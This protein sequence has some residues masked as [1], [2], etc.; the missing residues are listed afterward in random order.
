MERIREALRLDGGW[1]RW[2]MLASTL[3]LL[4]CAAT[5]VI[6]LALP[7]AA[8]N[9]GLTHG[10]LGFAVVLFALLAFVPG[11]RMHGKR[12]VLAL[13]GA[14]IGLIWTAV[15]LPESLVTDA[16]RDGMTVVGGLVMVA[17]HVV[18]VSLCRR[19]RICC[20]AA[21]RSPAQTSRA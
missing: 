8:A 13:G 10:V 5:P 12:R 6:A 17:A 1:D 7:A 14:G 3:C 2:G 21:A 4:H 20:R 15:L 9:E 19:C 11:V 16:V 18:N